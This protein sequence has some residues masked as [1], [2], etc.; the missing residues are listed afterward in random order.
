MP[1]SP[2]NACLNQPHDFALPGAHIDPSSVQIPDTERT[3]AVSTPKEK[4]QHSLLHE[5]LSENSFND[6]DSVPDP[7]IFLTT[8]PV[9]PFNPD[10]EKFS[11]RAWAKAVAD[12][13]AGKGQDFRRIGLCFQKLN[14][15]GYGTSDDFQKDVANVWL[16]LP[17]MVHRIFSAKANT[18]RIDILRSFDGI[19]LPGEMCVVLGPPG[20]GCSTFL[21]AIAAETNGIYVNKTSYFNYHGISAEE[22]HS[23]HRGDAIYT[24]EVDVHFPSLSVGETLTFASRARSQRVLPRG[25]TRSQYVPQLSSS[26][27]TP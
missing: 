19:I 6:T 25:I 4:G 10:S 5:R 12:I 24:A 13:A 20:S 18:N 15:F 21:K 8:S 14:V 23:S 22:L 11:P 7:D 2:A 3:C 17:N 9:S 16:A 27:V 1:S 26:A